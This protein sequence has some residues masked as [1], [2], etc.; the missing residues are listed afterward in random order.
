MTHDADP[1]HSLHDSSFAYRLIRLPPSATLHL[2]T[3]WSVYPLCN[4][5]FAYRLIRSPPPWLS[6]CI[7]IQ[8]I[9]RSN[10]TGGTTWGRPHPP[11]EPCVRVWMKSTQDFGRNSNFR[12]NDTDDLID[13][14]VIGGA[15]WQTPCN[16]RVHRSIVCEFELDPLNSLGEIAFGAK[17]DSKT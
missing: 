3:G 8:V 7:C 16:G 15:T 2:H 11:G 12:K 1:F 4:S 13:T 14:T 6:T 9:E 5:S 10:M 17:C